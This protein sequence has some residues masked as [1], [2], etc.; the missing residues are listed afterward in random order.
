MGTLDIHERSPGTKM[1]ARVQL[2]GLV[3]RRSGFRAAASPV[4]AVCPVCH[5]VGDHLATCMSA[6]AMHPAPAAETP[7]DIS[8]DRGLP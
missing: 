5:V 3:V 1:R 7:V 2:R 8:S 6:D 4:P